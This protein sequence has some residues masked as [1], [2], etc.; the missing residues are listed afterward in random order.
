MKHKVSKILSAI[1]FLMFCVS[2]AQAQT[3]QATLNQYIA[4]LRKNPNDYALREKIIRHVQTMKPTPTIPE[5]A[6]RQ[7]V[8]GKT[9]FEDAKNVQEFKEAIEKFRKAL[10]IAPWWPEAN[11]DLGMA[12]QAAQQY[13]D[14][15]KMLKLYI[16]C[17]PGEELTRRAQNEIYKIE[18]RQE[19]AVKESSPQAVAEQKQNEYEKWLK[20]IDGRRYTHAGGAELRGVTSVLDVKGKI[21]VSGVI[22]DSSSL[23]AGSRGYTEQG[24]YEIRGRASEGR[25]FNSP[26]LPGGSLRFIYLISEEGDRITEQQ[27]L[28]DGNTTERIFLW[29]R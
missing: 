10:L 29:Q 12:L 9:L 15:I 5:E 27:R 20:K 11:R 18:A 7:Y 24:R 16:A 6:R 8:M 13:D 2:I 25:V 4:D 28:G 22:L 23:V 17:N 26:D 19:K 14:A 1:F 21:L 3:P